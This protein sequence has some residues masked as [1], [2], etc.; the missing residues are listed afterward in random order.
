M[1]K[2]TSKTSVAKKNENTLEAVKGRDI[3]QIVSKIGDMSIAVQRELADVSAGFTEK[4]EEL[5]Q[6]EAAIVLR[7]QELT[8]LHQIDKQ[9]LDL[10][11]IRATYQSELDAWKKDRERREAEWQDQESERQK[12]LQREESE[13]SYQTQV[14]RQRDKEAFDAEVARRLRTEQV[15]LEAL[16]QDWQNREMELTTRENELTSLRDQVAGFDQRIKESV[17]ASE[18]ILGNTLKKQYNHDLAL[19]QKDTESER[20]LNNQLVKSLQEQNAALREQLAGV[21][22]QLEAAR[23]DAKEIT[24]QALESASGRQALRT[25][26]DSQTNQMGVSKK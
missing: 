24:K 22:E 17:A 8:E 1:T 13:Y 5:R 10:E 3:H 23:Q 11:V 7:Q 19:A 4:L 20:K 16:K 2:K 15:R 26:Q 21:N 6:V 18:A 14:E 9:L 12:R 25:L